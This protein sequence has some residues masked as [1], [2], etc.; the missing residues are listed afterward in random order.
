MTKIFAMV[1]SLALIVGVAVSPVWAVGDKVRS[2]NAAGPAGTTGGGDPQASRGTPAD[3]SVQNLSVQEGVTGKKGQ[4]GTSAILTEDEEKDLLH[5]REEEKLARDVY[6]HLYDVWGQWIFENIAA[7]EQQHMDAVKTLLDRY[8]IEDPVGNKGEGVFVEPEIQDLYSDLIDMGASKKSTNLDALRVGATIE[9][10]D[11]FDIKEMLK[12]TDKPDLKSVYENLMKGS[13][14]HLRSFCGLL[15]T[16]GVTYE[17]Q[18]LSQK[19][20]NDILASPKETGPK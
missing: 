8:G 10:M 19:E 11:I 13:R 12:R 17:A 16:M 14:N 4:S 5:L 9:D 15:E 6:L 1:V 18:F 7:S 20:V 2:D 3:E